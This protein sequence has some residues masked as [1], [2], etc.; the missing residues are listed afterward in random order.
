VYQSA[1]NQTLPGRSWQRLTGWLSLDGRIRLLQPWVLVPG[2]LMLVIALLIPFRWLFFVGYAWLLLVVLAYYW[3]RTLAQGLRLE[4]VLHDSWAEVGDDLHESWRLTNQAPLPM[5]WLEI[6]D[7]TSVPGYHARRVA[8][9]GPLTSTTWHTSAR[10]RQRGIYTLGPTVLRFS[11]PLGCIGYEWQQQ[12]TRRI[13]VYPALVQ[14]PAI[15][16]RRGQS[17]GLTKADLIQQAAT[18]SVAGLREYTPG[19]LLSRIHWP[20]VARTQRL[21]VKEFDQ[22]RAGALWIAIDLRAA[23]YPAAQ[24]VV[25]PNGMAHPEVANTYSQSSLIAEE[26]FDPRPTTLLELAI[27]LAGSFAAQALSEGRM[28]GLLGDDGQRRIV[29]PGQ[30][31]QHLWRILGTLVE[32][33]AT[34]T[35]APADLLARGSGSYAARAPGAALALITADSG[36]NWTAGL[37]GWQRG[38][39]G[40]AIA[41]LVSA[42]DTDT[43]DLGAKLALIGVELQHFRLGEQLAPLHPP[44][45]RTTSRISPL[46]RVKQG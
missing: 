18:P 16:L 2:P 36:G 7:Q 27:T 45:P 38:Q 8:A 23:I 42:P 21:M 9:C 28:V 6:D 34:G 35:L 26:T 15:R 44:R 19:D 5:L 20:T 39:S 25:P 40:S 13:V 22:E 10:C 14:L 32:L 3:V 41:M 12:N 46:G 43:H 4:R 30:G 17:G 1:S 24:V 33:Q 31:T 37:A 29:P 11:D